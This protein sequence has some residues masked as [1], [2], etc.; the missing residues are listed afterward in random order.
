MSAHFG[1]RP[2][3]LGPVVNAQYFGRNKIVYETRPWLRDSPAGL[4]AAARPARQGMVVAVHAD[5]GMV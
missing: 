4:R 2:V 1:E 5:S 3:V